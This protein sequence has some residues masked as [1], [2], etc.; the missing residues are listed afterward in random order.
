MSKF[1]I[2]IDTRKL[3]LVDA[4]ADSSS[5][6]STQLPDVHSLRAGFLHH[7]DRLPHHAALTL[8]K[9]IYTYAEVADTARRWAACLVAAAEGRPRRVGILAYRSE[10]SYLGVLASLFAGAAFVPLNHKFPLE[11][12]RAMIEQADLDALLVDNES[13]PQLPEL[14]CGLPHQL[15]ILLPATNGQEVRSTLHG[16]VFDRQ[17]LAKTSPLSTLPAIA[18]DDLAYLLFTS[19]STGTPKGVP[20]TH[21]NVRAFLNVNLARYGLTPADRLTQTFDQTFD[22]SVFD[23]FMAWESGA[24]VCSMQPIELLAP[25]RFLEE[26]QITVYFSVPSV[27]ALLIKR[28]ALTPGSMPTLRWSLFCG[29]GL[30]R[31]IAEAWQAAAPQSIIENLYGPTEL[32]IA[33]AA[34]RWNSVTSPAE[35]VHD[36]VPIGEVYPGLSPLVVDASLREVAPGEVGELCVSGPQTSP[37]Y[38]RDP[39]LT[40]RCFFEKPTSAVTTRRYYRTG[41]LVIRR[42]DHY[43]YLGR[44]DQQVKV[45]GYRIELGEIEAVLRR[46]GCIEAV[47]L[48]W[49][50][51]HHPDFIVAVV[52][53]VADS[54][55]LGELAAQYLP[56]YIMPRS[57]FI[58][59][60]MPLNGN[61]K[62]DRKA[63]RQWLKEHLTHEPNRQG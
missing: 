43:V 38:W 7:A 42:G 28:V 51:E 8:G 36:L 52:S 34:Y 2:Q 10:T 22:L 48:P 3:I 58:L 17:D 35:C 37:E 47:A 16:L 33:C 45:S 30:P 62:V 63:L 32:T 59:D 61:G 27:A 6:S 15:A 5:S 49:P 57:I 9:R 23:L 50:D 18:P 1:Y 29:E 60:D 41:D 56:N 46:V 39:E 55:K 25:F 31:P 24:C 44:S 14:L 4:Q 13:L 21:A 20:I 26:H 53:G 11:R 54:S 19:G 40:A 12:T